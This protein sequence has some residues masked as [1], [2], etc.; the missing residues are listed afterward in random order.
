MSA[1]DLFL[2]IDQGGHASRALIFNHQ[3]QIIADAFEK[4]SV[5]NP[6]KDWVE[7]DPE[8][9][10]FSIECT[11]KK[12]IDA[13]GQRGKNIL[14]A[15]LTTQRSSIV[16]WNNQTGKALS[17]VISWQDR[18][19]ALWIKRFSQHETLIHQT[20][21][22]FLTAH[23]GVSKLQWCMDHIPA[24]KEAFENGCLSW[25]PMASFLIFRLLKQHPLLADPANAS[26]TLLWNLRSL[27]WDKGL[28]N[29]FALPDNPL[30]RCVPTRY[31]FGDLNLSGR[32]IPMQIVTGDQ[33]AA[34][35][36]YGQL[37]LKT[38]YINAGTGAFIQRPYSNY[39]YTGSSS[40][41][42]NSVVLQDGNEVT[43]VLE[44]T[45]NGAGSALAK[46]EDE[47]GIDH[48]EAQQRLPEWLEN[49]KSPLLF[50]NGISGL[51]AP[52]WIPDFE[53]RFIGEGEN[54]E[55]MVGVTESIVFL[56]QININEMQKIFSSPEKILISGGLAKLDGLCQRLAN[57]SEVPVYRP[58]ECEATARGSA[59]L[60]AG[61]PD[62]WPEIKPG[63][64]FKP[65]PAPKLK[66][67]YKRWL[68]FMEE[69]IKNKGQN[70]G[71]KSQGSKD[72]GTA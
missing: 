20:T 34:L 69:T 46:I 72:K 61:C 21:G 40:K 47:L 54:W 29:L 58:V 65:K 16:C 62:V 52:F 38:V 3:G 33:S 68:Y 18:R 36:G 55:K 19:A 30:P 49:A 11:V 39:N 50:L 8:E 14:A 45:V 22:L 27:D 17:P 31:H 66:K 44:G 28:L 4:I 57:L 43:Y 59:Y 1:N 70:S 51:G 7:H 15:G 9:V 6:K 13:V 41:L 42:L 71:V 56:L 10:V 67:R 23:Y 64:W 26:R 32:L 60:L 2:T 37:D 25:G 53:S 12:V 5:Q 24:V 48:I 63:V 35:F